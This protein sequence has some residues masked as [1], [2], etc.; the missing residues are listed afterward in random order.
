MDQEPA[1]P[2]VIPVAFWTEQTARLVDRSHAEAPDTHFF[3]AYLK[4]L[5]A[6]IGARAVYY[7]RQDAQYQNNLGHLFLAGDTEPSRHVS[8]DDFETT[9][10]LLRD[11]LNWCFRKGCGPRLYRELTAADGSVRR[12]FKVKFTELE[13]RN[14]LILVGD[15]RGPLPGRDGGPERDAAFRFLVLLSHLHN[16]FDRAQVAALRNER[17]DALKDI[18]AAKGTFAEVAGLLCETWQDLLKAGAVRLWLF[19]YTLKEF[20]LLHER[21]EPGREGLV[22]SLDHRLPDGSLAAKSRDLKTTLRHLDPERDPAWWGEDP[23]VKA[24]L[25]VWPH[26]ICVP[27]ILPGG[28]LPPAGLKPDGKPLPR[29]AVLD[30]HL[31]DANAVRQPD[32]RLGFLGE[33]SALALER[34]HLADRRNVLQTLN[35]IELDVINPSADEPLKDLKQKYLRKLLGVIRGALNANCVSIFE[36]TEDRH[37]IRCCATTG[38]EGCARDEDAF[39][40]E[41]EGLTWDVFASGKHRLVKNIQS[42]PEYK[43]KYTELRN[44]LSGPGYDPFLAVPL[45]GQ[46]H[47]PMGVIRVLERTCFSR[48]DTL[49]NFSDDDLDLLRLIASQVSPILQMFR[50]GAHREELM[51]RVDHG[52]IQPLQAIV[53]YTKNLLRRRYTRSLDPVV[54]DKLRYILNNAWT[55]AERVRIKDVGVVTSRADRPDVRQFRSVA[56]F[57]IERNLDVAPSRAPEDGVVVRLVN[58]GEADAMGPF[59]VNE[60]LFKQAVDNIMTNAVKYCYPHTHV[61]VQVRREKDQLITIVTSRGLPIS[62]AERGRVFEDRTRG[63]AAM[64]QKDLEG[65]GQGLFITRAI[66]KRLGG[67][68]MLMPGEPVPSIRPPEGF[69]PTER[70]TFRLYLPKAFP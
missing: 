3:D 63:W 43:G 60:E 64:A 35:D 48:R 18:M 42:V 9:Y 6:S 61:D 54:E 21:A 65:T 66:M 20:D 33:Q 31:A 37:E 70:T 25:A 19:N 58:E 15:E 47:V 5:R 16:S 23:N 59:Q 4:D 26:L 12:V 44:V 68:V 1:D 10:P 34:S 11:A 40:R 55:A 36:A 28:V 67:D 27:F 22:R 62:P 56:K 69:P 29:L 32:H 17:R 2:H 51:D 24:A 8:V 39:Y 38:L 46:S 57:F 13:T 53:A 52:V 45:L 7:V 41:G 30:I 50:L 49:Q 14:F